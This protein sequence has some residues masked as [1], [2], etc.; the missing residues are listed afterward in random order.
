MKGRGFYSEKRSRGS[1]GLRRPRASHLREKGARHVRSLD[2]FGISRRRALWCLEIAVSGQFYLCRSKEAKR[3][4]RWTLPKKTD[5]E[6]ARNRLNH[7][8]P[9]SSFAYKVCTSANQASAHSPSPRQR[10]TLDFLSRSS[11]PDFSVSQP[12]LFP[13]MSILTHP[14]PGILAPHHTPLHPLQNPGR[15]SPPPPG[16]AL[17]HRNPHTAAHIHIQ[18]PTLPAT[19]TA[20]RSPRLRLAPLPA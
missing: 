20:P 14:S 8:N 4:L 12:M 2:R 18:A 7:L 15:L 5:V 16:Q 9:S 17:P 11:S 10:C 1:P 3:L 19:S 13:A 6:C